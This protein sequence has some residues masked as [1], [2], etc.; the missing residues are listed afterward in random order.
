MKRYVKDYY[1]SDYYISDPNLFVLFEA[2][3][4]M[5]WL[6][7]NDEFLGNIASRKPEI[8]AQA[9][10]E[11]IKSKFLLRGMIQETIIGELVDAYLEGIEWWR[12]DYQIFPPYYLDVKAELHKRELRAKMMY[13]A[14]IKEYHEAPARISITR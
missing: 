12:Q 9:E 4:L 1:R 5:G 8:V 3:T 10:W 6:N 13:I 14:E 2:I 7:K 11:K